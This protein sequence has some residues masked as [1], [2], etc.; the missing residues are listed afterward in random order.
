MLVVDVHALGLVDLLYLAN[1]VELGVG[2]AADVEQLMGVDRALVELRAGGD[3][4][5]RGHVQARPL[6]ERVRV[7]LA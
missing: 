4:V 3:L 1:E 5:A 2:P 7:L 6:R